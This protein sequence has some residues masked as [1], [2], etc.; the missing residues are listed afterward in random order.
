MTCGSCGTE[1]REGR[2]FC[3]E[4]A[5]PLAVA[6]PACGA[7]NQPDEKFCGECATLLPSAG[8]GAPPLGGGRRPAAGPGPSPVAERRLVSVLF[9][10]L[11]GFTPFAE[12]KDPEEVREILGAVL[13]A[14]PGGHRALRRH[15][16]EVHRR[17]G[18][19]LWGA[20]VAHEDDA[21]RAVRAALELV[22]AVPVLGPGIQ[23]RGGVLT[24]EAAVTLGAAGQGTGRRRPRQH[25]SPT[26]GRGAAGLGPRRRID[27]AG[28]Q[29]RDRLRGGRRAGPQG[30]GGCP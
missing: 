2:K 29:R 20:P 5:A 17:R 12:E 1:N 30:Q 10:D 6:C 24:G 9:A 14:R 28:D 25:C 21:E 27:D 15:G 19:G 22:D 13:R 23:A 11:V 16:R 18:H 4:C 3:S 8:A 7:L 26:A